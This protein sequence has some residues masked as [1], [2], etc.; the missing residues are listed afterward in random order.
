MGRGFKGGGKGGRA[1]G[2]TDIDRCRHAGVHMK[3]AASVSKC[4]L[5][6]QKHQMSGSGVRTADGCAAL[7]RCRAPVRVAWLTATDGGTPA[8]SCASHPLNLNL[9]VCT[10]RFRSP[11]QAT[12]VSLC[13]IGQLILSLAS[14]D[15]HSHGGCAGRQGSRLMRSLSVDGAIVSRTPKIIRSP[16]EIALACRADMNVEI[17]L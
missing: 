8:D 6:V 14:D 17:A 10:I 7:A 16:L 9:A 2:K 13:K 12:L 15:E 4:D 11:K 5:Q 3:T 1:G